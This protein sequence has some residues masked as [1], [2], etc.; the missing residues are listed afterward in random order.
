MERLI[1]WT[2]LALIKSLQALPLIAVVRL[3]RLGGA[4]ACL[5]DVRHRRVAR[6]NLT[7]AFGA[8]LSPRQIRALTREHFRR[9]GETYCAAVKTASMSQDQLRPHLEITGAERLLDP[10]QPNRVCFLAAGHF[11]NFEVYARANRDIPQLP[12]ATT[13][14]A[15]NQPLLNR[16]LEDL[17]SKSGCRMFERRRDIDA[18][19]KALLHG[20]LALGFLA[21][22]HAGKGGVTVPFF[23]MDCSTNAAP[24]V[25]ALRYRRPLFT[26]ICYRTRPGHWRVEFGEE[27]PTHAEGRRRSIASIMRDVNGALELAVRRDPANWFWVHDRWRFHRKARRKR[28]DS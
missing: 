21:D 24:A 8:S 19:R 17:R 14:R 26:S 13:Y 9:L 27:I 5:L 11:G 12:F 15:L 1:Y 18:M 7:A 20:P 23:G 16:L 28:H 6:T 3:G 25:F 2:A 4:L 22:Q 10:S